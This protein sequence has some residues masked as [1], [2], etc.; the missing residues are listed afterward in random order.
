[1]KLAGTALERVAI[2]LASLAL[3][4]GL[5]AL[6]SGFFAG[7]DQAGVSAG[8]AVIGRAV[9]D[10]GHAHLRPGE[11]RPVYNSEPPT[12]GAH[13]PEPVV[14]DGAMLGDDQLLQALEVGDVVIAYGTPQPPPGLARLARQL[15]DSF[16][17]Q[18]AAAGQA[19][20]TMRRPRT[21]GLIGLA[22]GRM[23][24]VSSP[25]DPQLSKFAEQWLGHGAPGR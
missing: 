18:L 2:A 24:R 25:S 19:V 20:L 22:W 13:I 10:L 16:T 6:L 12:S 7:R 5:I 21:G 8:A 4:V 17:P 23:V 14:H 11:L 9:P 3:S 15:S 1:M